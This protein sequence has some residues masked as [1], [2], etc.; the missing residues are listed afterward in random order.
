MSDFTARQRQ[1]ITNLAKA[2]DRCQ[3]N[4]L[5]L[6]VDGQVHVS[7]VPDFKRYCESLGTGHPMTALFETVDSTILCDGGGF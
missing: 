4:D 6:F 2:L 1:A 3:R 7:T 5:A